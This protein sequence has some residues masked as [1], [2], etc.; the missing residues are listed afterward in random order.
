MT[1]NTET[2]GKHTCGLFS[3]RTKIWFSLRGSRRDP[4]LV[5]HFLLV[6][7]GGFLFLFLL[8]CGSYVFVLFPIRLLEQPSTCSGLGNFPCCA[9]PCHSIARS[10]EVERHITPLPL[11]PPPIFCSPAC[12]THPAALSSSSS[13]LHSSPLRAILHD[14]LTNIK[15]KNSIILAAATIVSGVWAQTACTGCSD[16]SNFVS[17]GV[18]SQ[19]WAGAIG[20]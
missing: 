4:G 8:C 5:Q 1:T 7:L 3:S 15:M 18:C 11:P 17:L 20:A 19:P 16:I 6:L 2:F 10:V 13:E 12:S 14:T 9:T